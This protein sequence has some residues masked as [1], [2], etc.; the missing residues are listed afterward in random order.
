MRLSGGCSS[1]TGEQ[2]K[3]EVKGGLAVEY[4][5]FI[6]HSEQDQALVQWLRQVLWDTG[7]EA[8]LAEDHRTPGVPLGEKV[9]QAIRASD[10]LVV[11]L[12][13]NSGHS[14]F[15]H[16]EV[17]Y[18]L[19]QGKLVIPLLERGLDPQRVLGMLQGVEYLVLDPFHPEESAEHLTRYLYNLAQSKSQH[20]AAIAIG[21]FLG[22]LF[23]FGFLGGGTTKTA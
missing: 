19:A 10:C 1:T 16:Q 4:R 5:V 13:R 14:A 17:G 15:V 7:I 20:G 11:V 22:T 23:L 6:S 21:L 8:Y 9:Q 12:T 18:A 2:T 3:E